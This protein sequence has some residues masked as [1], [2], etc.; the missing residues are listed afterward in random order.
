MNDITTPE[1]G[2]FDEKLLSWSERQAARAPYAGLFIAVIVIPG[3]VITTYNL[4]ADGG[5]ESDPVFCIMMISY[6]ALIIVGLIMLIRAR[7]EDGK[8]FKRVR[9]Y[10]QFMNDSSQPV[11]SLA[12]LADAAGVP[13]EKAL[14]DF[15]KIFKSQLASGFS[16]TMNGSQG[17]DNNPK[18]VL[19][20]RLAGAQSSDELYW[21]S[22]SYPYAFGK[23]FT[24]GKQFSDRSYHS[25]GRADKIT[26]TDKYALVPF[27][28]VLIQLLLLSRLPQPLPPIIFAV[29]IFLLVLFFRWTGR[30]KELAIRCN[31][32]FMQSQSSRVSVDAIAAMMGWSREKTR[33]ALSFIFWNKGL[34]NCSFEGDEVML[35]R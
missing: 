35:R 29:S 15:R 24:E 28:V 5:F 9:V 21:D 6:A 8:F 18:I 16:L 10:Q 23:G 1:T 34:V 32:F 3:M 7:L 33:R 31:A 25:I 30:V 12:A 11:I 2:Y 14:K 19:T 27:P 20:D 4:L 17:M 13:T 26:F 22:A